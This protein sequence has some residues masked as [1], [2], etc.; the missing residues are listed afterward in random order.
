MKKGITELYCC[1]E[2]FCRTVDDNFANML[3]SKG[4][5]P[6]RI[7]DFGNSH[8]NSIISSIPLQKFQSFLPTLSAAL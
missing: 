6:T 8:H 3:L 4:R 2:D 7:T 5:K 1:I